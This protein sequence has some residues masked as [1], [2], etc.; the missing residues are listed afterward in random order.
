[1]YLFT[2]TLILL[3][4]P[5]AGNTFNADYESIDSSIAKSINEF[6]IN[7]IAN[8]PYTYCKMDNIPDNFCGRVSLLIGG[9]PFKTFFYDS[10]FAN[11]TNIG[12]AFSHSDV[13][14]LKSKYYLPSYSFQEWKL[15]TEGQLT[16]M[17]D[18][19]LANRP[20]GTYSFWVRDSSTGQAKKVRLGGGT[21]SQLGKIYRLVTDLVPSSCPDGKCYDFIDTS[22][23]TLKFYSSAHV[24]WGWGVRYRLEGGLF[25]QQLGSWEGSATI[26]Q[27]ATEVNAWMWKF[28]VASANL[29]EMETRR[30]G[31]SVT[32]LYIG[33]PP[34]VVVIT[35]KTCP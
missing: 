28:G 24:R 31:K 10:A 7:D 33:G 30:E 9:N 12:V 26:P 23:W 8:F 2:L 14:T 22:P 35:E 20:S 16:F 11:S 34:T 17:F 19:G 27:G 13:E 4:L 21:P 29:Y 18:N 3:L 6:E 15:P 5:F 32:C 1:M 25:D